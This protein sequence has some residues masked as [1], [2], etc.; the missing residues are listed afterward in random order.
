[1]KRFLNPF[2]LIIAA[3]S[4]L[5]VAAQQTDTL[6]PYPQAPDDKP[7]LTEKCNYLVY[8]FWERCNIKQSFS[9][10][11]RLNEA[12]G[13]WASF[14]PYAS[15]DTVHLA[16]ENYIHSVEKEAPKN[17]VEVG[18]MAQNW[19]FCDTA[20][21]LSEELY[22]PFCRA[23]ATN[24]KI[25]NAE[26][27]KYQ[28]QLKVLESSG[29]GMTVPDFNFITPSGEIGSFDPVR[30]SRIILFFNDPDCF[31]CTLT[32][33]RLSADYNLNQL[34][35]KGLVKVVSI[36]PGEATPEWR[37]EAAKYPES[38]VVGASE[39]IYEYF[40]LSDMPALYWLD[41]RHKVLG[42]D[43]DINALLYTTSEINKQ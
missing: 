24:K 20:Q 29:L 39:N 27:A 1:M 18:R 12:F 5:T 6:F 35:E 15:A 34:I 22:L 21:Y 30:A 8:N 19:F 14:M 16:I 2:I 43:V 9:S 28:A 13:T 11:G 31:D 37:E 38:W 7:T 40:D 26:K 32:K 41:G 23:V 42:K 36:Y 33:T 17:L 25:G 10:L 4:F 3:F